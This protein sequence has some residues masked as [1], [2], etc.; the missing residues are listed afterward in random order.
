LKTQFGSAIKTAYKKVFGNAKYD[1]MVNDIQSQPANLQVIIDK[2]EEQQKHDQREVQNH[3]DFGC[4]KGV[5][6]VEQVEYTAETAL[7]ERRNAIVE[8]DD[9]INFVLTIDKSYLQA[10]PPRVIVEGE[11]KMEQEYTRMVAEFD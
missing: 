9:K 5:S 11:D 6:K 8:K 2:F 1:K 10:V 3:P 7:K 4:G